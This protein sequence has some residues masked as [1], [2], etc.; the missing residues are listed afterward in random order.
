MKIDYVVMS[1]DGNEL[2]DNFWDINKKIWKDFIGVKPILVII[3]DE[4]GIIE[5]DE[6]IIVNYKKVD[7][8]KTSFQSQISR[9]FVTKLFPTKT[10]LTSDIDMIPLNKEYFTHNADNCLDNQFLNYVSDAYGYNNQM[11]YPICYNLAKGETYNEIL[12]LNCTFE[13]F[14]HRLNNLNINPLWDTDEIYLGSCVNKFEKTNED[15]I[16]KIQRGFREGYATKRIDRNY[17]F[18]DEYNFN[19]ISEGF[20]YDC[21]SLRPYKKYKE[22]I[23]KIVNLILK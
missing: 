14:V 13:E 11:R 16:V 2:Y 3:G 19:K 1:T 4:D 10:I 21:H 8:I 7:N 12:D 9:L 15:R 22:E 23:D 17:W 18:S 20:Y 5:N 6:C